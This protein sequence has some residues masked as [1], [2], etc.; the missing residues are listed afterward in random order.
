[1]KIATAIALITH[2]YAEGIGRHPG[3]LVLDSPAAEEMPESD[4]ATMVEA[5]QAVAEEAEMQ[6]FVATRSAAPLI[7]LLPDASRVVAEG[8]NYVW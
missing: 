7:D 5:L 8:D 1:V 2:G 3:F 4:L 6:I